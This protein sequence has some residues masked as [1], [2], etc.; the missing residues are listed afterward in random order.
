MEG[1][2]IMF[3]QEKAA[4]YFIVAWKKDWSLKMY[5]YAVLEGDYNFKFEDLHILFPW[6]PKDKFIYLR[7]SKVKP[8][9]AREYRK[10]NDQL[11]D[12]KDEDLLKFHKIILN[13]KCANLD[14]HY[15]DDA[16]IKEAKKQLRKMTFQDKFDKE[17]KKVGIYK[18]AYWGYV[19]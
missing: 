12:A 5:V 4:K 7:N 14:C 1:N 16:E 18:K 11:Y 2:T 8:L 13:L 15:K 6:L 10:L 3:T 19:K 9:I 17:N